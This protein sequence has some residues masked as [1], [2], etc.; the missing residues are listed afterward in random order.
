MKTRDD[1]IEI[2]SVEELT[3]HAL[4]HTCEGLETLEADT[5]RCGQALAE[6]DPGGL[7][8]LAELVTNLRE[9][10]VF[11]HELCDFFS[12]DREAIRCADGTLR[13]HEEEF[14]FHLHS[15]VDKLEQG[16]MTGI[17][18]MLSENLADTLSRFRHF[19]PLLRDHIRHEYMDAQT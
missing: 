5:R 16:D 14:Q 6:Q 18:H 8:L 7:R 13:A 3:L 9:F 17:A 15:L 12:I 10:D 4:D 11:E 1:T 19:V 2:T